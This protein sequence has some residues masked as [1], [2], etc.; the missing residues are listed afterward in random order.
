MKLKKSLRKI[1]KQEPASIK[2]FVAEEALE[3]DN[4][5]HFFND[6]SN[7]GCVSGMVS[8]L[9]YYRQTH[10]FFDT[11]YEQIETLRLHYEEE[12]GGQIGLGNDLKNTLAWFA[13]EETA[14]QLASELQI[15]ER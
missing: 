5:R 15:I 14:Y 13:F 11:Y 8:S 12:T 1:I 10:S 2:A 7:H 3:N 4:I 9:I 6:L